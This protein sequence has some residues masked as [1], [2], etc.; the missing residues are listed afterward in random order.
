MP[1]GWHFFRACRAPSILPPVPSSLWHTAAN[2]YTILGMTKKQRVILIISKL[3]RLFPTAKIMLRYSSPWELLVAVMLSAQCTDKMVNKVTKKLFEKY[4]TLD[5]YVNALPKEFEQDI[6]STGFYRAKTKHILETAQII[7]DTYKG[8]LPRKMEEMTKLPG[9]G[10]KTANVVLGNAF[11]VVEGIAV[12]THVIR[13]T[14]VLG[15]TKNSDPEKIEKDLMKI[16]PR[17]EWLH[18]T[19]LLIEYG[20]KYCPAIRHDHTNCPLTILLS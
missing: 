11:G 12:D 17:K 8:E 13:I 2:L 18:F 9:V 4:R 3:K 20:R 19:Y 5:D 15:L 6:F 16:V 10:R 7:K 1:A 14:H